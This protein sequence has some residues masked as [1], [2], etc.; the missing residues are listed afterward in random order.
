[1]HHPDPLPRRRSV[2]LPEYDYSRAGLYFV[3]VCTDQRVCVLGK[4]EDD[5]VHLSEAGR[6][7]EEVWMG[8]PDRFP[9]VALDAHVVMPNHLHGLIQLDQPDSRQ[10]RVSLGEV[11]RAFKAATTRQIRTTLDPSFAWQR[12]YYEHVVRNPADVEHLRAYIA[13][14]PARWAAR[15]R[16]LRAP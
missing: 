2:R 9:A 10:G 5:Q 1:M 3:T 4:V 11:V 12:S 7:A 14:N 13:G 8:L 15:T 6:I 16:G